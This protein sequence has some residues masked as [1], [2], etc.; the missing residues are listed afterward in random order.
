MPSAVRYCSTVVS[1]SETRSTTPVAPA[2]RR[3][4]QVTGGIEMVPSAPGMGS[5]CGSRVDEHVGDGVLQ[6]LGLA[7]HL[8]PGV[9]ELPHEERLDQP[10]PAH[11]LQ[12]QAAAALRQL[13][14]PVALVGDQPL[15]REAADVLRHRGR[16]HA[17]PDRERLRGDRLGRPLGG[18][19]DALQIVLGDRADVRD[20]HAGHCTGGRC[21]RMTCD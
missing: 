19:P 1:A 7:V 6:L 3:A 10:V 18:R 5:P 17:E 2:G 15:G 9:A 14:H 13:D 12:R 20:P 16:G 11:H 4:R 21:R 8:V